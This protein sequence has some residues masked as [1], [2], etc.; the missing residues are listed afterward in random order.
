M[1]F[2]RNNKMDKSISRFIE[3][4][5]KSTGNKI[6][7]EILDQIKTKTFVLHMETSSK[8]RLGVQLGSRA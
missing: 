6:K 5:T 4:D 8:K 7:T 2:K 3:K 1:N